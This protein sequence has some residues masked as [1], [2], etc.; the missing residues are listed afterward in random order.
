MFCTFVPAPIC[1]RTSEMKF[2]REKD[3]GDDVD[4]DND[5]D[6]DDDDDDNNENNNN[7]DDKDDDESL[8]E[9]QRYFLGEDNGIAEIQ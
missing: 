3:D 1:L 2:G 7:S 5:A 8:S 4:D 9:W 6:D